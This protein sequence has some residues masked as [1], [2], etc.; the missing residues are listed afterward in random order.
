MQ[1]CGTSRKRGTN[2]VGALLIANSMVIRIVIITI[3][4]IVVLI[5][6]VSIISI[7]IIIL[8]L[9]MKVLLRTT[10]IVIMLDEQSLRS[11]GELPLPPMGSISP[12]KAAQTGSCKLPGSLLLGSQQ[13]PIVT[14]PGSLV[15]MWYV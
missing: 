11:P 13:F 7:I 3:F 15:L 4:I 10:I 1:A 6:I 5:I 9:I 12:T 8:L 14:V 2:C